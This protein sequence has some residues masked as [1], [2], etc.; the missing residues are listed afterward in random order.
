MSSLVLVSHGNFCTELKASIEMIMGKQENIYTIPLLAEDGEREF[1]EK[2]EKITQSLNNFVVFSDLL[3]GTPCNIL[4]K[5]IMNGATFDL[6]AGM[7][8]PMVISF[9]NANLLGS[10]SDYVQEAKQNTVKVNE[11]L[12]RDVF[13]EEDE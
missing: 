6:Y 2:F 12:V 11:I 8:L 1:L 13:Y 9:I 7:N 5:K 3:G 10:P 4:S